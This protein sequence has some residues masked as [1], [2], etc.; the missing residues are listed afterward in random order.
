MENS[1]SHFS[2][3]NERRKNSK[4]ES[5]HKYQQG[6][7]NRKDLARNGAF[8]ELSSKIYNLCVLGTSASEKKEKKSKDDYNNGSDYDS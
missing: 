1:I 3:K 7:M 4:A 6:R 8:G 5:K 2:V